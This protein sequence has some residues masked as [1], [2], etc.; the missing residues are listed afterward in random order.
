MLISCFQSNKK[1]LSTRMKIRLIVKLKL[2]DKIKIL[3]LIITIKF[4]PFFI[5]I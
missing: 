4:N 2:V 5:L 3:Y 1:N